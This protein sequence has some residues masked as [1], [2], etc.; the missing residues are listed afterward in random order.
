ME[1][2]LNISR[3]GTQVIFNNTRGCHD[4]YIGRG[5]LIPVEL[6][7]NMLYHPQRENYFLIA[8]VNVSLPEG[9]TAKKS[10]V[11]SPKASASR[12]VRNPI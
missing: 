9:S 4:K 1:S 11:R 10:K 6:D 5:Y 8:Q 12:A 3:I 2:V 7:Y